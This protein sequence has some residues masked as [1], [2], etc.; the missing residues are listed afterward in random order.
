VLAVGGG[1][2]PTL[3][4]FGSVGAPPLLAALNILVDHPARDIALVAPSVSG[5]MLTAVP[6]RGRVLAGTFQ[7]DAPASTAAGVPASLVDQSLDELRRAFPRLAT[8]RDGV[9]LVHYGL[10]PAATRAG[11]MDLLSEPRVI[12]HRDT[13]APGVLSLVGVKYT[14]S[15]LAAERAVDAVAEDLGKDA[16]RCKTARVT[17]PHAGIADVEGRLLETARELDL[18]LD[19]DQIEYLASWYGTEASDVLHA[20]HEDRG[21]LSRLSAD[22]PVM[23]AEVVY[24][25]QHA[26]ALR[27]S[28]VV[29]RRTPLG[30]AGH[31]GTSALGAAAEAMAARLG[32]SAARTAE[33]IAQ[34]EHTYALT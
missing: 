9:R 26:Q 11:S 16:T 8:T 27:L 6:W 13:G 3:T 7:F 5:R 20:V 19:R 17:L 34:V 1:L 22:T 18:T 32:W 33:E 30:S 14:T 12:R 29:L 28:D 21:L 23:A 24:A 25:I 4:A 10:V 2:Q 15:R 31:P